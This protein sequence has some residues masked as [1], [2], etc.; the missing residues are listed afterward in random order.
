M[1]HQQLCGNLECNGNGVLGITSYE[2]LYSTVQKQNCYEGMERRAEI[3]VYLRTIPKYAF[4]FIMQ[5][6]SIDRLL[7]YL[8]SIRT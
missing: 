4:Y 2:K 7:G 1:D 6:L 8:N 5:P 3:T